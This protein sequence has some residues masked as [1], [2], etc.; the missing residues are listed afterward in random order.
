[1]VGTKLSRFS[2]I[3]PIMALSI[4]NISMEIILNLGKITN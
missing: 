1:M 3:F 4:K 2:R